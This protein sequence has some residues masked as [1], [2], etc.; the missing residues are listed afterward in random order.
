MNEVDGRLERIRR[1]I[2][3]WEEK[4]RGRGM[5]GKGRGDRSEKE[6]DEMRKRRNIRKSIV[7]NI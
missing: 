5:E 3:D 6:E 7:Y 2:L 4:E 1:R